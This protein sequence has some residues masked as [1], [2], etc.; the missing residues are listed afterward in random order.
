[1]ALIY[2]FNID[3]KKK[4]EGEGTKITRTLE[5]H[6]ESTFDGTCIKQSFSCSIPINFS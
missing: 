3:N 5:L 2:F 6:V 1:M 4:H